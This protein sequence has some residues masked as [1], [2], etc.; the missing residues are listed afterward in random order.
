VNDP[1]SG[2]LVPQSRYRKD[3]RVAAVMVEVNR[4]LYL[5]EA[6]ASPLPDFDETAAWIQDCCQSA[7]RSP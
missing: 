3:P 6:E 1:F 2:A 7:L 4:S 5:N